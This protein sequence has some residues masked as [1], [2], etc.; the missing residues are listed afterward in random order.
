MAA[1]AA[2][3]R[4]IPLFDEGYDSVPTIDAG[5]NPYQTKKG[6]TPPAELEEIP[7][8]PIR[9]TGDLDEEV[10]EEPEA[11]AEPEIKAAGQS[12]EHYILPDPAFLTPPSPRIEQNEK[13]LLA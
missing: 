9:H 10:I 4:S 5:V 7:I 11:E 2:V 13:E 12:F 8:K 6:K 1:A 3:G